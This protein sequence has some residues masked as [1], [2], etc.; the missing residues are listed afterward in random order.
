VIRRA[1][2]PPVGRYKRLEQ[3]IRVKDKH[4]FRG[5]SL[6]LL[7]LALLPSS[8]D[9]QTDIC[10]TNSTKLI[11]L[12]P[13]STKIVGATGFPADAINSTFAVQL[14]ELPVPSGPSGIVIVFDKGLGTFRPAESLGP[15]LAQRGDTI[16]KYKVFL[17]FSYQRFRFESI[18]GIDLKAVPFAFQKGNDWLATA[19]NLDFKLDQYLAVAA[20]GLS[21]R[22]DL[23]LTVPIQRVSL[24]AE[25]GGTEYLFP[26]Y[27]PTPFTQP[28]VRGAASGIGDI[29]V[30]VKD[31]VVQ[32]GDFSLAA[33]LDV[34]I[35]TGDELNYL[36]SGAYGVKP[37]VALSHRGKVL[38]PHLNFGYQYNGPSDILP[39]DV[40]PNRRLPGSFSYTVGTEVNVRKWM[41]FDADYSGIYLKNALRLSRFT[42]VPPTSPPIGNL[43]S[44]APVR[45]SYH[46]DDFSAGVKVKLY[47]SLIITANFLFRAEDAG[48]KA[49]VVPLVGLSYSF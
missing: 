25:V 29:I 33:A 11:C 8:A 1:V 14:S 35:P 44:I 10:P 45:E 49:K 48:L 32:K 4:M 22:V 27:A 41:A 16:G 3:M 26:T 31:S 28:V 7:C 21:D 38:V 37:Y 40:V 42:V 2:W 23:S 15:I 12:I 30:G 6:V 19:N 20:V 46:T 17:G 18:D 5:M 24:G 39:L 34:R 43:P 47:G 13:F 9:A 36:G